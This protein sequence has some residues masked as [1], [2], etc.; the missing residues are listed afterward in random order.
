MV[1]STAPK[2]NVAASNNYSQPKQYFVL[3]RLR[4]QL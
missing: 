4:K 3:Q 2:P 1:S